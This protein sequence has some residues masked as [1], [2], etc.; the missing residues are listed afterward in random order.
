M[1]PAPP[2]EHTMV[3]RSR[4][5]ILL[6]LTILLSGVSPQRVF[7]HPEIIRTVPE[8]GVVL[9]ESPEEV[10]VVFNEPVED[11]FSS[12]ELFDSQ[13]QQVDAGGGGRSA[14]DE[15]ALRVGLSTIGPGV[16]TAV[17]QVVGSDGHKIR[18][19]FA[20]T[21][22]GEPTTAPA[23][24]QPLPPPGATPSPTAS[25]EPPGPAVIPPADDPPLARIAVLRALMFGGSLSL[26]GGWLSLWTFIPVDP[27]YGG[28]RRWLWTMRAG[29]ALLGGASLAFL[30]THTTLIAGT[31][32]P[33]TLQ[34]TVT[35]TRLGQ[36]LMARMLGSMVLMLVLLRRQP[37]T[38]LRWIG[39][40]VSAAMLLTFSLAGH[41]AGQSAPLL[42]ISADWIHML[43]TAGWIGGLVH[44][45]V[46]LPRWDPSPDRAA[47]IDDVARLIERFSRLALLCV[48][49]LTITGTYSALRS[50]T[51][52]ADLWQT[53]YGQALLVK[54][55]LFGGLIVLGA[56]NLFVIRPGFGRLATAVVDRPLQRTW[57]TRFFRILMGEGGLAIGVLLATGVLTSVPTPPRQAAQPAPATSTPHATAVTTATPRLMTSTPTAD[58]IRPFSQTQRVGDLDV[59]LVIAPAMIGTNTFTVSVRTLEGQP[60]DAQLVRLT[61]QMITMDMGVSTLDPT[62]L[63]NGHYIG[64]GSLLSMVGDWR[65]QVLVRRIDADDVV[66]DFIVPVNG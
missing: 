55:F 11:A 61:I 53:P 63:G 39:V 35:E 12:L 6:G 26:F 34:L 60:L 21:I 31:V 40:T 1:L 41:A 2:E 19:N 54:L 4:W 10:L 28:G 65:V 30:F 66:A 24:D 37:P 14:T 45:L 59:G 57:I 8:A 51:H 20:F 43:A 47:H 52:P 16:Y 49:A 64:E 38:W 32:T 62:P 56:Y 3:K 9:S 58:P 23:T 33:S 7:A 48:V 25:P 29:A 13:G 5:W 22:R 15:T 46:L 18:G 36:A 50:I 27:Q 17:W 44:L 42:P